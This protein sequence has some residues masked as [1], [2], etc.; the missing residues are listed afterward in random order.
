M[1]HEQAI[2]SSIPS[3]PLRVWCARSLNTPT[4]PR[5]MRKSSMLLGCSHPLRFN[6]VIAPLLAATSATRRWAS[7]RFMRMGNEDRGW[8]HTP[9]THSI[10]APSYAATVLAMPL[11]PWE[12][13]PIPH[14]HHAGHVLTLR[15]PPASGSAW[16][17][18][19][20]V[21]AA[22]TPFDCVRLDGA[23]VWA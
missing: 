18:S 16:S 10:H 12:D 1:T 11:P 19:T 3:L 13:T 9:Y 21:R 22:T 8:I 4:K 20:S 14:A 6:E 5:T 2:P 15:W 17:Y 23:L 7:S